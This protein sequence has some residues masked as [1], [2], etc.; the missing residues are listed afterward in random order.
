MNWKTLLSINTRRARSRIKASDIRN[1]FEKDYH[2][3][4]SS[5]SFR[6]LQDKTQAFPLEENDFV[7]TRLTHSLEVSSFAKSIAQSI[8]KRII[9]EKLDP[10]FGYEELNSIS[11]ILSSA[12]LI[13]DIGNPPF[14]HFGEDT[15]RMWFSEYIDKT[16]VKDVNGETKKLRDLLTPQMIADFEN[17]EGNAQAIRVVSKL[18]FLV[19]EN[20]MNLT[21]ALLNSLIKYPVSSQDIDKQSG[22]IKDK[23]MGYFLAEE[24]VFYDV[25][26]STGTYDEKENKI[27]RHPLTFL[28]EA[29][30][31]IAYITADIEDGLK[32]KY[33]NYYNIENALREYGIEAGDVFYDRLIKYKEDAKKNGYRNTHNYAAS[34]WIISIQG[35]IIKDVV[36]NFISNYNEIMSG[37]FT[38]EL[39]AEG[40]SAKIV[41][42]LKDT[43]RK[44]IFESKK[45]NQM[46]L[47][48][49]IM[50]QFLLDKFVNSVIYY[51]TKFEKDNSVHKKYRIIL[52][53][54]Q[55]YIYRVYAKKYEEEQLAELANRIE[56]EKLEG[57][58][59]ERLEQEYENKIYTYKLYLRLLL[60]TDYISGMTDSYIKTTYQE[61]MGIK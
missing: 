45:N 43:A 25:V 35:L 23:K 2:R 20:G 24:D 61:L 26:K 40:R 19:D 57:N 11:T 8:G 36:N 17:F 46:E 16:D 41:K 5:P 18:H 52:S 54:N 49:N 28:L 32:K 21:Y 56:E 55:K 53:E 1:D 3:V 47:T 51:D 44:Y 60:V 34:R 48:A 9:E 13:H 15:I 58:K 14:G 37:T 27:Y 12:A 31:D 10:D 42:M 29:A 6:R 50:I 59:K 30:D 39:L 7:R 4:I 38:K 33:L 22:N